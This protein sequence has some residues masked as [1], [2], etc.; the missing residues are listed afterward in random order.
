MT[1]YIAVN[2][3]YSHIIQRLP[4]N[5]KLSYETISHK[6]V[7][8]DTHPVCFA[9][10]QAKKCFAWFTYDEA[11]DICLLLDLN[12]DMKI[13]AVSKIAMDL[14][15]SSGLALGTLLYGSV[16]NDS[17]LIED[18]VY[19]KGVGLS[20][21]TFGAKLGFIQEFL[22]LNEFLRAC[23]KIDSSVRFALPA[24][25]E[26]P[27]DDA[28]LATIMSTVPYMVHHIQY[29]PLTTIAP[30]YN[31]FLNKQNRPPWTSAISVATADTHSVADTHSTPSSVPS[32]KDI[33]RISLH[34]RCHF[35]LPQYKQLTTFIVSADIQYD[36]YHLYAWSTKTRS[37][38]YYD[39]A[40]IPNYNVSVQMNGI[41][42]KI[43]ENQN[44]DG[45]EESDDEEDFQDIREDKHVDLDKTAI[46]ECV[47]HSKFK[48]W[49]PLRIVAQNAGKTPPQIVGVHRL[50]NV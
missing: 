23:S 50:I 30:L 49:V 20:G 3:M 13:S 43:R 5:P 48:R 17:F 4:A 44:L 40:Y 1:M 26:N 22:Q 42:R 24:F 18:I 16:L 41:F 34:D 36:I 35:G 29:R 32:I 25:F 15:R 11:A 27:T 14:T 21:L 9:I 47:F 19:Y 31:V 2:N 45:I 7:S 37:Y 10:P 46:M 39:V 38:I 8:K 12:R 6:K 28:D 33:Y